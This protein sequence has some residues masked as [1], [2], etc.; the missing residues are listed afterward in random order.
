M[1]GV[2]VL[3]YPEFGDK[4]RR[5]RNEIEDFSGVVRYVRRTRVLP[6]VSREVGGD[7]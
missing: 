1:C 2:V 3:L 4:R 6:G 7:S 5:N